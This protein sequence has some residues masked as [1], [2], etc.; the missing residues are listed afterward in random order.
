[1]RDI[2]YS[3]ILKELIVHVND[4]LQHMYNQQNVTVRLLKNGVEEVSPFPLRQLPAVYG[5]HFPS[6]Q[7]SSTLIP[8]MCT[9]F[10][11]LHMA[12]DQSLKHGWIIL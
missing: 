11:V 10:N 1:M 8:D 7:L 4:T 2:H 12:Y 6:C 3:S 9:L 5:P